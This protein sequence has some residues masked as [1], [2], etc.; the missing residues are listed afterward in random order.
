MKFLLLLIYN[1]LKCREKFQNISDGMVISLEE[2]S[3]KITI[4]P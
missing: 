4:E 1:K 3:H 2:A